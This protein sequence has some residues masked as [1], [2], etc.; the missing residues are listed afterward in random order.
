[1]TTVPTSQAEWV[2]ALENEVTTLRE[3]VQRLRRERERDAR[4]L[5]IRAYVDEGRMRFTVEAASEEASAVIDAFLTHAM[6]NDWELRLGSFTIPGSGIPAARGSFNFGWSR[7]PTDEERVSQL[8]NHLKDERA[9][10]QK[11]YR[12]LEEL[13]AALRKLAGS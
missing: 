12:D 11:A 13:Q 10:K 7:R 9:R 5:R 2:E 6:S 3:E 4:A 1:M 8:Q